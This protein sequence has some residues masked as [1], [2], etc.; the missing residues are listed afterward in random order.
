MQTDDT[1]FDE[2]TTANDTGGP[3][4]TLRPSEALDSDDVRNKDG[5]NAV[6]PT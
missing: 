6:G 4:D 3:G 2:A 5:D 1:D